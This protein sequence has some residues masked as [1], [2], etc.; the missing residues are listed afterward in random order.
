MLRTAFVGSLVSLVIACGTKQQPGTTTAKAN[1]SN[2]PSGST[3]AKPNEGADAGATPAASG[4]AAKDEKPFAGS[5]AEAT[6][7]ISAVVDKKQDEIATCVR[8]FRL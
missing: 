3:A 1:D 8:E 7:I 6:S 2:A 5:S 4:S